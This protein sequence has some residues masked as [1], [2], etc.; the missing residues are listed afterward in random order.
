M[1]YLLAILLTFFF[2]STNAQR[3]HLVF[4]SSF[5]NPTL[6]DWDGVQRCFVDR[7]TASQTVKKIGSYSARFYSKFADTL[8]CTQV[9][10]QLILN[11]T[12]ATNY[13]RWYGFSVYFG[14]SYP[15]NYDGI[16]NFIEFL[17]TDTTESY[18][19]LAL[20]YHGYADGIP[21]NWSS[22]KYLTTTRVLRT[23][24]PASPY[25]IFINPLK[26]VN[27]Q[28]WVDIVMRV[29]WANDTSGR[30]RI[31]V[32]DALAFSYNGVTTYGPTVLRLGVDKWDWRLKW[33]VSNTIER[34]LYIDEFRI[35]D[36]L[37][38]YNDVRPG[39]I[40]ALPLRWISFNGVRNN[41]G[42]N[43]Y[44]EATFG[45][46]FDRFIVERNTN[47]VWNQI[48]TVYKNSTNEYRFTDL[49]P[50]DYNQYRIR[51]IN[52]G[53]ADSYSKIIAI[54]YSSTSK[55]NI[56]IYNTVGQLVKREVIQT[57]NINAYIKSLHLRAGIY[58]IHYENGQTEKIFIE[59]EPE[60]NP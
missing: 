18:Y 53:E 44:W 3:Q 11:D 34:E 8:G 35:G 4:E 37:A 57:N 31:W 52:N 26:T 40:N 10:S 13:E 9:R 12:N 49:K 17:R 50:E 7:V 25:T 28:Q 20:A 23:P 51:A 24:P 30:V 21:P 38:T 46:N 15:L 1:R 5:E 2:L 43:L 16:E 14:P 22:G 19:P 41:S 6:S 55:S 29:K 47:G 32:N 58:F 42:V 54:R 36:S 33:Y 59:Y 45:S 27:N 48:G 39:S 60:P 56:A